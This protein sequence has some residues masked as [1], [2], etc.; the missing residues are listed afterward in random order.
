MS[1][2]VATNFV[3]SLYT[4]LNIKIKEFFRSLEQ[5]G[6]HNMQNIH[7]WLE[8]QNESFEL[9]IVIVT[10]APTQKSKMIKFD[11][12]VSI[13]DE[14]EYVEL[15]YGKSKTVIEVDRNCDI[16]LTDFIHYNT[17][18]YLEGF[19]KPPY[20]VLQMKFFVS[21]GQTE[22][23]IEKVLKH[24][25]DVCY[26][27]LIC[28]SDDD[29]H[30]DLQYKLT[31]L[32]WMTKVLGDLLEECKSIPE[33]PPDEMKL[34]MNICTTHK[35]AVDRITLLNC[36]KLYSPMILFMFIKAQYMHR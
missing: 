10:S 27:K 2:Q 35:T 8:T 32:Q 18:R 21:S 4:D 13:I 7:W 5:F 20:E 34:L 36:Y 26:H 33:M 29:Y 22:K 11:M 30:V 31:T 24:G 19:V 15:S 16:A 14:K 3:K 23:I 9:Y 28:M 1:K 25:I 6:F 17:Y 12:N